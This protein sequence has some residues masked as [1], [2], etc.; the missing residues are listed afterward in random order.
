MTHEKFNDLI[1]KMHEWRNEMGVPI[2]GRL[3]SLVKDR[4][5]LFRR[6]FGDEYGI[7]TSLKWTGFKNGDAVVA[8]AKITGIT[9]NVLAS[10]HAVTFIGDDEFSTYA[11]V[12]IAETSAIG[13]ALACFGMHGGEY[14]S[15]N[16]IEKVDHNRSAR[17][18]TPDHRQQKDNRDNRQPVNNQPLRQQVPRENRT[19]L[20]VPSDHEAM[21]VQPDIEQQKIMDEVDRIRNPDTLAKYYSELKPWITA[22]EKDNYPLVAEVK[23]AF[24]TISKQLEA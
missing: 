2:D 10:G 6:E 14:A 18:S 11:P 16:E 22:T 9:G 13:R 17:N 5:E 8:S 23:A 4:V 20:Y 7:D 15:A 3:Y 21:W 12:E 24:A 19:G 1:E